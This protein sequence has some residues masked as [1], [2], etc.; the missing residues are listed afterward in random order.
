MLDDRLARRKVKILQRL[1]VC[2]AVE[3]IGRVF[4]AI[5]KPRPAVTRRL[6]SCRCATLRHA[7]LLLR[8]RTFLFGASRA[9]QQATNNLTDAKVSPPTPST[10]RKVAPSPTRKSHS[11]KT[12]PRRR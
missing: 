7:L 4:A 11:W 6:V 1:G 10:A 8:H 2:R 12:S 9:G 3:A 5:L